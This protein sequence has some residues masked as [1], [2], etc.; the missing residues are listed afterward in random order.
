[1]EMNGLFHALAA[2]LLGKE[3]QVKIGQTVGWASEHLE[4]V[5]KSKI[6]CSSQET[7]PNSSA[8]E[9]IDYYYSN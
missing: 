6:A 8:I 3:I 9:I 1:M 5:K 2:L 4:T 7:N